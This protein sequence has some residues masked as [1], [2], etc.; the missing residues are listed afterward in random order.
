MAEIITW[1]GAGGISFYVRGDEVRGF[2]DLQIS[3]SAETEDKDKGGEK[4]TSKKNSGG[5]QMSFTA[6]FNAALGVDVRKAALQLAEAA[7]TFESG[8][9]YCG[10]AKL[11][12]APMAAT[13]AKIADVSITPSGEW[14]ACTVPVT[15][16]QSGKY[17]GDSG[18]SGSGKKKKKK[19]KSAKNKNPA[20]SAIDAHEAHHTKMQSETTGIKDSLFTT[21]SAK[22]QSRKIL[23]RANNPRRMVGGGKRLAQTR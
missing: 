10:G 15:F 6:I 21:N 17:G 13:D 1:S 2:K 11:I 8:Y 5:Y 22:D 16:K 9:F 7:R 3:V 12:P 19:K 23:N 20:Q 18:S 4:Y 14:F